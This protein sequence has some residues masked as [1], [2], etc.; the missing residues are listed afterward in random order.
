MSHFGSQLSK[1]LASSRACSGCAAWNATR[2]ARTPR[3]SSAAQPCWRDDGVGTRTAAGQRDRARRLRVHASPVPVVPEPDRR[4]GCGHLR[5]ARGGDPDHAD[6]GPERHEGL[7]L[8]RAGQ[9][10]H[11]D[12]YIAD[13]DGVHVVDFPTL[14]PAVVS[15]NEPVPTTFRLE[16]LR[17]RLYTL[18]DQPD[19]VPHRTFVLRPHPPASASRTGSC[20]SLCRATTMS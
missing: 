3:R 7:P 19:V 2:R 6:G 4:R 1:R 13:A 16:E 5:C 12:A 18:P 20:S 17:P 8:D 9:V 11:R 14:L 10:E 15:Y